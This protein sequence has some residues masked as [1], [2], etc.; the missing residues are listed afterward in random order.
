MT[1]ISLAIWEFNSYSLPTA[2]KEQHNLM[3][4]NY[5]VPYYYIGINLHPSNP[6]PFQVRG[7]TLSVIVV[8]SL[9]A[10]LRLAVICI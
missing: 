2:I 9:T 7:I 8:I 10:F 1:Q 5:K 3:Y 4:C 6:D